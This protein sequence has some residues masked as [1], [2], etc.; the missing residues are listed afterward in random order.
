MNDSSVPGSDILLEEIGRLLRELHP[1]DTQTPAVWMGAQLDRDL[2]LDSLSRMELLMRLEKRLHVSI[3]ETLA[4]EARTPA[5]L[6]RVLA[7]SSPRAVTDVGPAEALASPVALATPEDARTLP[8]VLAW[9]ARQHPDRMHVRFAG[10]DADGVQLTYAG[11]YAAAGEVA[12]GLQR[13]GLHEGEPVALMFP[14][15]PDL[16]VAFFAVMF[17]GGVPVPLYPPL[18]PGELADYWGRQTGILRNCG[19]RYLLVAPAIFAHRHTIGALA[20]GVERLLT[21]G[22]LRGHGELSGPAPRRADHLAMLQYTSG[23]TADPKGVMLSHDNL[24]ANIRLMGRQ[25]GASARDVFVSWLPLYHD[26]A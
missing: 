4:V 26:M 1:R 12:A 14:T 19:A 3:A 20:G 16:L 6:L 8:E 24:L 21:V 10:G 5:E 11:L 7:A 15:H 23:S 25:V 18:R 17:A 22:S 9:H 13:E 2:G